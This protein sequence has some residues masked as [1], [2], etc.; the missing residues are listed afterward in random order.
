M[1]VEIFAYGGRSNQFLINLL[2]YLVVFIN[3]PITKD[4]LHGFGVWVVCCGGNHRR[5]AMN[6]LKSCHFYRFFSGFPSTFFRQKYKKNST[7]FP[8]PNHKANCVNQAQL[9]QNSINLFKNS[10]SKTAHLPS[11]PLS[12]ESI[13][14]PK[15]TFII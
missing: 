1:V 5:L 14:C 2:F 12:L 13:N 3:S 11:K 10:I 8:L 7:N 4:Q 6:A 15:R 9:F